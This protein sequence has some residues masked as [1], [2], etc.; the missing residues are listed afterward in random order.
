M[1][2]SKLGTLREEQTL[3][4]GATLEWVGR[5]IFRASITQNDRIEVELLTNLVLSLI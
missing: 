1:Y 2:I 5:L 3:F 4:V